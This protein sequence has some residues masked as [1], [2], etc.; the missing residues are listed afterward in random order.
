M[1]KSDAAIDDIEISNGPCFS[2]GSCDFEDDYC[3]YYN[4][5][6]GDNFDWYRAKGRVYYLTGPS[7][8]HTTNT[9]AGYYLYIN[10]EYSMQKGEKAWL[11][12]ETITAPKSGCL[13]WYMHL[14]GRDIGFFNVYQR[15]QNRNRTLLWSTQVNK[16]LKNILNKLLTFEKGSTRRFLDNGSNNSS[17]YNTLL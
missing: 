12:S 13:S 2:E 8:D 9:V 6:E 10:T 1:R 17:E 11:I 16:Y 4:T 15:I 14:Y 5:K 3:G 7:V